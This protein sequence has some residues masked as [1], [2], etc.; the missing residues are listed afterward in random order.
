MVISVMTQWPVNVLKTGH[1]A[2]G[3]L[4]GLGVRLLLDAGNNQRFILRL[5]AD[6]RAHVQ[7]SNLPGDRM[8]RKLN[9]VFGTHCGPGISKN[10]VY[11]RRLPQPEGA[12]GCWQP[13]SAMAEHTRNRLFSNRDI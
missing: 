2:I 4:A 10:I 12:S 3:K 13:A 9:C 8:R 6:R 5:E 11:S 1:K 7:R